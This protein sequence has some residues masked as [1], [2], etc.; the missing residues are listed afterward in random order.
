[1]ANCSSNHLPFTLRYRVE[2][3]SPPS[4]G[5]GGEREGGR[6]VSQE[7]FVGAIIKVSPFRAK[8]DYFINELN[9]LKL[10]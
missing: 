10:I 8:I 1:M 3:H 9:S 2:S 4:G 5:G 6:M 7:E